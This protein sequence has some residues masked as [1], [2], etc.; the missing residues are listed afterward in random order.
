MV[1]VVGRCWR[2]QRDGGGDMNSTDA[3][4]GNAAVEAR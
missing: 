3:R 2:R 4:Q 1:V